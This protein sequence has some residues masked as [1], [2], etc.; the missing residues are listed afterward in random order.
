MAGA[1]T[2]P[3]AADPGTRSVAR[4]SVGA[5]SVATITVLPLSLAGALA[6]QVGQDLHVSAAALGAAS[7][8]F[9]GAATLM[10]P[11]AGGVVSRIGARSTMRLSLGLVGGVLVAV[12]L[13]A[14]SLPGLL[15]LLAVGGAGNALAQ[16]ATNLYLA[17][18]VVPGRQGTAYGIKQS[19][20][21]AAGLL[22]GLAVPVLA[23]TVGWRWAFALF[24]L[25]AVLLAV[26]TPGGDEL[27][28][29]SGPSG[30]PRRLPRRVL[31]VLAVGAGLGAA[32]AGPLGIF[33]VSGAVH[34]GWGEAQAGLL[35][36]AASTGGVAARL[37]SGVRA[38]R[39]GERHLEVIAA[40]LVLGALG[41]AA[42]ATGSPGL[43]A[44]GS[45]LA[46]ALGWGWP[47][48]FVLS[49]VQL[50][51]ADPAAA[52]ALTQTGTSAGAVVGPL[53]F[54][55]LVERASYAVAWS[56]AAVGLLLAAGVVLAGRRMLTPATT[57]VDLRPSRPRPL[58]T[59]MHPSHELVLGY[60]AACT[61]GDSAGIAASFCDDAVVY[62]TNHRPVQGAAEIGRFYAQVREQRGGASWHVDTFLG[63]EQHAASEW[64][65]LDPSGDEPVAVRGSEHY[66]FRDGR[67]SQIRQYWRYDP[68]RPG[69][70]LR[71]YPYARDAR[72]T[73]VPADAVASTR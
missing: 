64:T 38:D 40:M 57:A 15:L 66:D 52:T 47:G 73:A 37:L 63:D 33:L 70:G 16:P 24:A 58:E 43:F 29:W 34:A 27:P 48:L 11:L 13:A 22:A 9:F 18:R 51:P 31:L 42:L 44:V 60:F 10:S 65:M 7:S 71:D 28:G 19:A 30:P 41:F 4:A 2:G 55:L 14:H 68:S 25:P 61:R 46:F 1:L 53:A 56:A 12:G 17:Q 21:P 50:S 39:R 23:L 5:V 32:S 8:A 59:R 3:S 26:R 35:F 69:A 45:L 54:G 49:V 20:I 6:V 36:A 62:D 72:F 67:I